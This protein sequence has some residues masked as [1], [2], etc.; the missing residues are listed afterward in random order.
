MPLSTFQK[1]NHAVIDH[2]INLSTKPKSSVEVVALL[3]IIPLDFE[4]FYFSIYSGLLRMNKER[5]LLDYIYLT[6]APEFS[7]RAFYLDIL[8]RCNGKY[9]PFSSTLKLKKDTINEL[10]KTGV[11]FLFIKNF[12]TLLL[13]NNPFNQKIYSVVMSICNA[14]NLTLVI[15]FEKKSVEYIKAIFNNVSIYKVGL[16]PPQ[17]DLSLNNIIQHN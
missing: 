17:K 1:S 12:E 15:T 14:L 8:I 13:S 9:D 7:E 4:L 3:N 6:P 11:R 16:N 10:H 2:L 5:E